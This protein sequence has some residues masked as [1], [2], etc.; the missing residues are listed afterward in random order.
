MH[1][2][3]SQVLCSEGNLRLNS[4]LAAAGRSSNHCISSNVRGW[5]CGRLW[6]AAVSQIPNREKSVCLVSSA[7]GHVPT[8]WSKTSHD[9]PLFTQP[10]SVQSIKGW[11]GLSGQEPE[12]PLL[13]PISTSISSKTEQ[14][15]VSPPWARLFQARPEADGAQAGRLHHSPA[16][17]EGL[18]PA[19]G[20]DV[21]QGIGRSLPQQPSRLMSPDAHSRH[22]FLMESRQLSIFQMYIVS[23]WASCLSCSPYSDFS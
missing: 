17:G 12:P 8:K 18:L 6:L 16:E 7:A 13:Y 23:S 21:Q 10:K 5:I 9:T 14:A 2:L 3:E 20:E 4:Y 11:P 19:A 15:Q 1:T 22:F